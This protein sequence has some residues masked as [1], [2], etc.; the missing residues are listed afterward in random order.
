MSAAK[1]PKRRGDRNAARRVSA[2]SLARPP[3]GDDHRSEGADF[4]GVSEGTRTLDPL[5]HNQMLYQL[6]YAHHA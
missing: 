4:V 6:S 5:D 2:G 1:L 3:S